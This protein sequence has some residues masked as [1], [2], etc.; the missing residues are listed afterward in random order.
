MALCYVCWYQESMDMSC[1]VQPYSPNSSK[2]VE[3]SVLSPRRCH[4]PTHKGYEL[5]KASVKHHQHPEGLKQ[6]KMPSAS[7]EGQ[8]FKVELQAGPRASESSSE[9]PFL[10]SSE[11]LLSPGRCITNLLSALSSLPV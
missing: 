1:P 8:M 11:F 3:C 9:E 4:E 5:P 2:A 6:M 10:A 7:S